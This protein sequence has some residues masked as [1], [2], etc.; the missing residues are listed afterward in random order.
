[1]RNNDNK[2][3]ISRGGLHEIK[4]NAYAF[5]NFIY[6]ISCKFII[7]NS[8]KDNVLDNRKRMIRIND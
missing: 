7:Y 8:C 1:M 6:E 2:V 4:N 5:E 3:L